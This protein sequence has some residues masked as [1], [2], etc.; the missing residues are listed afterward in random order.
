MK[1]W[2]VP[3]VQSGTDDFGLIHLGPVR[4]L[5]RVDCIL[6][7]ISIWRVPDRDTVFMPQIFFVLS[8]RTVFTNK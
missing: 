1:G 3:A 7:V 2:N 5:F 6:R 8:E 4:E